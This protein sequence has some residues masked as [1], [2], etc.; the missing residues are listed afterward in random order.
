MPA[1]GGRMCRKRIPYCVSSKVI[2]SLLT[3]SSIFFFML[4]YVATLTINCSSNKNI[5]LS[6]VIFKTNIIF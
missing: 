1:W 2:V 6:D 4:G 3:N 5:D